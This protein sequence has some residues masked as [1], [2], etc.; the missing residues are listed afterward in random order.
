ML[1]VL[2]ADTTAQQEDAYITL[3]NMKYFMVCLKVL[4][5]QYRLSL[6]ICSTAFVHSELILFYYSF[7]VN[8]P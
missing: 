3:C 5:V 2:K 1:L 7:N 4:P 6:G 8:H